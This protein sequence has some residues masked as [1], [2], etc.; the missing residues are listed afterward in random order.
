MTAPRSL[1]LEPPPLMDG[2]SASPPMTSLSREEL[3]DLIWTT[4]T[5][6]LARE[7]GISDVALAKLCRRRAIP[8]PPRGYWAR[9]QAGQHPPRPGLP[10]A[11]AGMDRP[12]TVSVSTHPPLFVP[13][14]DNRSQPAAVGVFIPSNASHLHPIAKRVLHC[15]RHHKLSGR[16]LVRIREP[17]LPRISASPA[18][19]DRVARAVD[20]LLAAATARGC[21]PEA[22]PAD[23]VDFRREKQQVTFRIEEEVECLDST[24]PRR[25]YRPTGRLQFFLGAPGIPASRTQSWAE[26]A[27][28]TLAIILAQVSAAL[29]HLMAGE[30]TQRTPAGPAARTTQ[31]VSPGS[32]PAIRRRNLERAAAGRIQRL[33]DDATAWRTHS[34]VTD[35][36]AACEA[37]WRQTAAD[38]PTVEQRVWL[39]WARR[40]AA[41]LS[42][43]AMH[44]ARVVAAP[45]AIPADGFAAAAPESAL[46][47][48]S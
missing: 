4:P 45:S 42:P 48:Q 17:G 41:N 11:P 16:G 30:R 24:V 15:L 27:T 20:S 47:R 2:S 33:L 26:S 5:I 34:E 46:A 18:Q 23:R 43:F 40:V 21:T 35:Y 1:L 37:Q 28:T 12:V 31:Q 19:A 13:P 39:E 6:H 25:R 29:A 8:T 38:A 9:L 44:A 10:E 3:Y 14:P 36:L 32:F 7:F 22:G